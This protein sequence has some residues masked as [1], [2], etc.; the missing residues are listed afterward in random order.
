MWPARVPDLYAGEPV[1]VVARVPR[2]VGEVTVRGRRA[3][4]PFE[5]RLPLLPGAPARGIAAL[6][7]R[8]K[9][10][11][12]LASRLAG[13]D[14]VAVRSEVTALALEHLLLSPFTSFVAVDVT[15]ARPLGEELLRGAV[16]ANLPAG[17]DA[18]QVGGVLPRAGTAA[19]L[20]RALGALLA[21]S[22][23]LLAPRRR[24]A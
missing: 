11:A 12:L 24:T 14:P 21:V 6:F 7:A 16:P 10:G 23:L 2:F 17:W 13:A 8:R 3:G 5:A 4:R 1:A 19:P 18:V 22:A 9:I 20:L 15:P